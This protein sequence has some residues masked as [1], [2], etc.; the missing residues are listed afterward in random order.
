[1]ILDGLTD[2]VV[3]TAVFVGMAH[4]VVVYTAQ[5]WLWLLGIAA[6]L[7]AA[8]HV[9]V[10]DARKKQYLQCLGL[11]A[12]DEAIS[13]LASQRRQARRRGSW[14]E[15]ILLSAYE[16]FR[17][18]QDLA[19]SPASASATSAFRRVNRRRMRIWTYM[20]SGTHFFALYVAA[21]VSLFWP[22]A[23]LACSLLYVGLN[24]IFFVLLFDGWA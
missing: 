1:M 13:V 16:F 4:E 9:W 12:P 6:G 2:N 18:A 14:S 22:P 10:F 15:V 19:A 11:T 20:G 24:V 7:S 17:R 8:A 21:L 5:P 3:G 23:L